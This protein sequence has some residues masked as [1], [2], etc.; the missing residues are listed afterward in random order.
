MKQRPIP[1]RT[2]QSESMCTNIIKD[3]RA[4][5]QL[6]WNSD[7]L[8]A[9]CGFPGQSLL[10]DFLTTRDFPHHLSIH[11]YF[12]SEARMPF[13]FFRVSLWKLQQLSELYREGLTPS[14]LQVPITVI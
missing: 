14:Q 13:I 2:I 12:L 1:S 6:P 11:T 8:S 3:Q 4:G 10:Y 9:A 7:S 5:L